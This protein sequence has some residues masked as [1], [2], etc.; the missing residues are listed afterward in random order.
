MHDRVC[1]GRYVAFRRLPVSGPLLRILAVALRPHVAVGAL[2]RAVIAGRPVGS[3]VRSQN[4]DDVFCSGACWSDTSQQAS[5]AL[6][7][8]PW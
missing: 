2:L 3:G 1:V 6:A 8:P 4:R 7:G 5:R